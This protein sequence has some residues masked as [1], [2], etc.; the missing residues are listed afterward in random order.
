MPETSKGARSPR[1]AQCLT[2]QHLHSQ[3]AACLNQAG[4]YKLGC[5]APLLRDPNPAEQGAEHEDVVMLSTAASS[6]QLL[7]SPPDLDLLPMP[8]RNQSRSFLIPQPLVEAAAPCKEL[9]KL[10][11]WS[12]EAVKYLVMGS[13]TPSVC[14]EL[15]TC[16]LC[17]SSPCSGRAVPLTCHL[18]RDLWQIS[19]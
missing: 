3:H 17:L 10:K 15:R 4:R 14:S 5:S 1:A 12:W 6:L 7:V 2:A 8:T 16:C 9:L 11:G 13:A 18:S 19:P